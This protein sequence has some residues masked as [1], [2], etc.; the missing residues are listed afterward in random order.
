MLVRAI[1]HFPFT[2]MTLSCASGGDGTVAA[3]W[4][5]EGAACLQYGRGGC[6]GCV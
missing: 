4:K 2:S 5:A 1:A 3:A 6:V